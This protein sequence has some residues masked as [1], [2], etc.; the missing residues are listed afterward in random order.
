MSFAV[1]SYNSTNILKSSDDIV[2]KAK[3]I[4]STSSGIYSRG[5]AGISDTKITSDKNVI[6]KSEGNKGMNYG[7]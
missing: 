6:I 1:D 2:L 5:V 4:N 7:I 3:S